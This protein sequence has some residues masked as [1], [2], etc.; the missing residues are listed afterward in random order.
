MQKVTP[1]YQAQGCDSG[2]HGNLLDECIYDILHGVHKNMKQ[3]YDICQ[4]CQTTCRHH[5]QKPGY[6]IYGKN[7]DVNNLPSYEC[8]NCQKTI[9]STHSEKCLGL[10]GRQSSRVA[11]RRM[12]FSSSSTDH[13]I[14]SNDDR[15]RK[16]SHLHEFAGQKAIPSSIY[17]FTNHTIYI[18]LPTHQPFH[19]L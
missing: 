1:N 18:I 5:V 16:T 6:D 4:I 7:Y 3:S 12:G 13:N 8:V 19:L 15:K 10:A 11:N 14:D 17:L 9:A 2:K